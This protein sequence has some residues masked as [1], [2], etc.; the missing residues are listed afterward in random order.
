MKKIIIFCLFFLGLSALAYC[1]Q[2][3]RIQLTDGSVI[4]GEIISLSEGIYTIN[5]SSLGQIKLEGAKVSKIETVNSLSN[6]AASQ[7]QNLNQAQ[8]ESYGKSLME[9]PKNAAIVTELAADSQFQELAKD[10]QL[11]EAA[12]AGDIQAMMKNE[13]FKAILENPKLKETI[14]RLKQ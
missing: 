7:A 4:N 12:K 5:T 13:K 6:S 9:D 1:G 14:K 2:A 10:P 8:V 11:K 3:S